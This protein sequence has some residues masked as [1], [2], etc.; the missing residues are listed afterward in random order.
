LATALERAIA[1]SSVLLKEALVGR[2][3]ACEAEKQ[4]S[5]EQEAAEEERARAAA[6]SQ[7]KTVLVDELQQHL[8]QVRMLRKEAGALRQ[9]AQDAKEQARLQQQH[10]EEIGHQ[11]EMAESAEGTPPQ[12]VEVNPPLQE[13]VIAIAAHPSPP[14]AAEE[15]PPSP[16]PI[17]IADDTGTWRRR[18]EHL[19]GLL[20]KQT[21]QNSA[22]ASRLATSGRTKPSSS[23]RSSPRRR[24]IPPAA[25]PLPLGEP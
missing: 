16:A 25:T 2:I 9:E 4:V 18:Y 23:R 21:K 12:A 8:V 22:M 14:A 1:S 20:A 13:E 5:L 15:E 7:E 11:E 6:L 24:I 3:R 10:Q 17:V 19:A